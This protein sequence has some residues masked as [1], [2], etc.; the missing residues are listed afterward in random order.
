MPRSCPATPLRLLH[1]QPTAAAR[2]LRVRSSMRD[3][4]HA[5]GCRPVRN[6]PVLPVMLGRGHQPSA[7]DRTPVRFPLAELN[8]RPKPVKPAALGVQ[9][10]VF[11]LGWRSG[12][13]P[14]W[15]GFAAS[16]GCDSSPGRHPQL[17]CRRRWASSARQLGRTGL[18]ISHFSPAHQSLAHSCSS[19]W[20]ATQKS[21]NN[22]SL[23]SLAVGYVLGPNRSPIL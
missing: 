16:P 17:P 3:G 23:A 13:W 7:S 6:V 2:D 12:G 15:R 14:T 9:S 4:G 8:Q 11:A 1:S 22:A 10:S 5:L 18:A 19:S 21:S 20:V